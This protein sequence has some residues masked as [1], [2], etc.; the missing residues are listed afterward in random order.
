M[1]TTAP[2]MLDRPA[3]RRATVVPRSSVKAPPHEVSPA[4]AAAVEEALNPRGVAVVLEARHDCMATRGVHKPE[5]L[6]LTR[7]MTGAFQDDAELRR[8]LLDI[9]ALHP[10]SEWDEVLALRPRVASLERLGNRRVQRAA[11]AAACVS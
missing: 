11:V 8:V 1:R 2:V 4:F 3:M 6:T 10:C 9:L 7:R 5:A